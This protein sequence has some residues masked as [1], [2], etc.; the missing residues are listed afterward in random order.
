[1]W[2]SAAAQV[3]WR[4]VVCA[5]EDLC[6]KAQVVLHERISK[7]STYKETSFYIRYFKETKEESYQVYLWS[8]K[9]SKKLGKK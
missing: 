9:I 4:N 6:Y 2:N 7:L 1:M 5:S 3:S 8:S